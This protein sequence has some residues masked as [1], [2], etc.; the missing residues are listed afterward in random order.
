MTPGRIH[1][2]ESFGAV[3]GPGVRFV[4]FLHGCPFRCVYCHN[5]DTWAAPAPAFEATA[6]EVFARALRYKS[7]WG[8]E[9]GITVSGGEP[10]LQPEF[11]CELFEAA[12]AKG[13]TTCID[14]AAGP[15]PADGDGGE[16]GAAI[17][18]M[19]DLAD[20]VL[21]DLKHIDS[22]A[23]RRITGAG[24]ESPIACAKYLAEIGK[25]VWIRHVLVPGLT[26][27]ESDLRRLSDFVRA[28]PNVQRIDVL[29]YHSMG[30]GK[31]RRLGLPYALA[32][33]PPP[34]PATLSLARSIFAW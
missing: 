11:V 2:C 26:D 17:R 25:P 23:H 16:R 12:K 10:M 1:S 15:F 34:T 20:T 14:T 7:Y 18:R 19:L 3:D 4:V 9:G 24:N 32:G 5:P 28:L 31:W 33:V 30:E 13:A 8:E 22:A 29:P 27:G 21:L 6:P